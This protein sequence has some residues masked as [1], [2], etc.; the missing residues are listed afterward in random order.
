MYN[1][2]KNSKSSG[3]IYIFKKYKINIFKN[4][5]IKLN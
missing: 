3:K 5:L 1:N 4:I 2:D